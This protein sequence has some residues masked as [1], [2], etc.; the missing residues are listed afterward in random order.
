[1]LTRNDDSNPARTRGSVTTAIQRA[2]LTVALAALGLLMPSMASA[3]GKEV[4]SAEQ[5]AVGGTLFGNTGGYFRNFT[6]NYPG[7]GA[8]VVMTLDA[9]ESYGRMGDIIGFNIYGPSGM[10]TRGKPINAD[11]WATRTRATFSGLDSGEY[12]IQLFS[13]VDR[14]PTFFTVTASGLDTSATMASPLGS[15][16]PSTAPL[17][18]AGTPFLAGTLVGDSDGAI[19]F[20]NVDYPGNATLTVTMAYAPPYLR[21]DKAVGVQLYDGDDLI[22]ESHQVEKTTSS[23]TQR[24][25][26]NGPAAAILELQVYNYAEGHR[27]DYSV[28]IKGLGSAPIAI[29]GNTTPQSAFTL[30]PE[31]SSVVATV[32]GSR[33]GG[34]NFF[35][36]SHPGR[37]QKVVLS[38]TTEPADP[39]VDRTIGINVYKGATLFLTGMASR[40]SDGRYSTSVELTPSEATF[41]GIQVFDYSIPLSYRLSAVGLNP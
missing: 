23:A 28:D 19:R 17:V 5:P 40:D 26:Y 12:L 16:D 22:A 14:K 6:I 20:Y 7:G 31:Q 2:G 41:F 38:F 8:I 15:A 4:L 39:I 1:M 25:T 24:L 13:Y 37:G 29:E 21:S 3:Q 30:T 35:N 10:V 18:Q 11:P 33:G 9:S 32:N 34:F 36:L 27:I